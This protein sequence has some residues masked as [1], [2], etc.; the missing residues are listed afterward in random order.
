MAAAVEAGT[1]ASAP[2]VAAPK[3]AVVEAPKPEASAD[4]KPKD[5]KTVHRVGKAPDRESTVAK[6]ARLMNSQAEKDGVAVDAPPAERRA[7]PGPRPGTPRAPKAAEPEASAAPAPK[8]AAQANPS[9]PE[10]EADDDAG[11]PDATDEDADTGKPEPRATHQL[12]AKARLRHGDVDKAIK[13]AFGEMKPE[14]FEAT[15]EALAKKLGVG[16]KQWADYR[17]YEATERAKSK[18]LEANAVQLSQR[19][20][21][22]FT[23]MIQAREAYKAKD[24]PKAFELAFGEDVNAFNQIGRAHV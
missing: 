17:R 16:S 19:L 8:P 2:S 5:D 18:Q 11:E 7:K 1:P 15:K 6:H 23:P 3:P 9:R 20:Q 12:K 21:S 10:A 13:L 22:E 4:E 14:E 24:Y